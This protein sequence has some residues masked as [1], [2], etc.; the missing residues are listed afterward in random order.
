VA[1]DFYNWN[2]GDTKEVGPQGV[3]R[4]VSVSVSVYCVYV[5]IC[6][7]VCGCIYVCVCLCTCLYLRVRVAHFFYCV[8]CV[9]MYV[10]AF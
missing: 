10:F 1:V 3:C 7:C 2:H 9:Y 4:F 5:Y 8:W 6:V